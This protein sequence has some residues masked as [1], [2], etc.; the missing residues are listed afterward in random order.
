VRRVLLSIAI[1]GLSVLAF[2]TAAVALVDT[3]VNH[4]GRVNAID[5][6]LVRRDFG[7]VVPTPTATPIP[8]GGGHERVIA[9]GLVLPPGMRTTITSFDPNACAGA[10]FYMAARTANSTQSTD[11]N[12]SINNGNFELLQIG[13]GWR[14]FL[15]AD[16]GHNETTHITTIGEWRS[17]NLVEIAGFPNESI[18]LAI[19]VNLDVHCEPEQQ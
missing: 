16:N 18:G 14:S 2:A 13:P 6:A 11:L 7:R 3:D 19:E 8:V 5:I 15:V 17:V 9:R 1:T 4:D 12:L 10:V